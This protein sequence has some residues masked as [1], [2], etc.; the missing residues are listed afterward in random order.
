MSGPLYGKEF[1]EKLLFLPKADTDPKVQHEI[2]EP[3]LFRFLLN[4]K[5]IKDQAEISAMLQTLNCIDKLSKITKVE[6]HQSSMGSAKDLGKAFHVF[7]LLKTTSGKDGDY[8]WSLEKNTK[9]IVMQRSPKKNDVKEKL[10][11]KERKRVQPIAVDLKGKGTIKDLFAI[12]WVYEVIP[13]KYHIKYS[14][15]QS[16]VTL[17]S[18]TITEIGYEYKGIFEYSPQGNDRNRQMLDFINI[19]SMC[20]EKKG[21]PL[22]HLIY[23]EKPDLFDIVMKS[24]KY[25]INDTFTDHRMTPL[26]LAIVISSPEMVRHLLGHPEVNPRKCDRKGRTALHLAALYAEKNVEKIIDLLL[27]HIN[28]N[29]RDSDNGRTALHYAVCA[30]NSDAVQHLMKK[31]ADLDS[32][33]NDGQ[34][35]LHLAACHKMGKYE[36]FSRRGLDFGL[37]QDEREITDYLIKKRANINCRDKNGCTPL[38][39]AAAFANDMEIIELLLANIEKE[40]IDKQYKNDENIFDYAKKN[41]NG[42]GQEIIARLQRKGIFGKKKDPTFSVMEDE[43]NKTSDLAFNEKTGQSHLTNFINN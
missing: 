9:Y 27:E 10:N 16:L 14:N 18:K 11:G 13:E 8:W 29:E 12:L 31:G 1:K 24:G 6:T 41:K 20:F 22:F 43:S 23:H 4:E 25:D 32:I 38:H 37:F 3:A 28:V 7:I 19:L 34:S 40:D 26:H 39:L 15:C 21:H 36:S 2:C 30:C 35:P 33:D 42:L 17:V 5:T